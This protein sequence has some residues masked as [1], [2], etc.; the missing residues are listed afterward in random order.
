MK[1]IKF[2][3]PLFVLASGCASAYVWKS[4]VPKDMRTVAVPVFVNKSNLQ[5]IGAI[6]S[7]QI[8]REFQREGTFKLVRNEDS[9]V[10][11]Q[12]EIVSALQ[13]RLAYAQR[14]GQ[15]IAGYDFRVSAVVSVI[16][17]KN[18]RV[19]VDNKTYV[20]SAPLTT[21]DDLMTAERNAA[22]AAADDLARQIVDDV[23]NL[24]W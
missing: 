13:G 18:G 7:R 22:G 20:G 21:S 19:L 3:L 24:K 2:I 9:A 6:A 10:E 4:S 17:H 12:G 1:L 23:L 16:D 8:L 14:T 15:R 5:E 11:I